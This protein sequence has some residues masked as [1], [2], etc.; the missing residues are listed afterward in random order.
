LRNSLFGRGREIAI[1]ARHIVLNHAQPKMQN[2][3]DFYHPH[4]F[5]AIIRAVEP[6]EKAT[7][8]T[9]KQKAFRIARAAL[10]LVGASI[11]AIA[12]FAA[13]VVSV[14]VVTAGIHQFLFNQ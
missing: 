13:F 1:F 9:A 12:L 3:T 14:A 8:L 11:V 2:T 7:P 10:L 6:Q 5:G 4:K